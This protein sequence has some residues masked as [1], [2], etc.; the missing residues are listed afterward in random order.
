[1]ISKPRD[2]FISLTRKP[3]GELAVP[4]EGP[5][6]KPRGPSLYVSDVPLPVT[7]EDV[8]Q[9][10]IAEVKFKVD[11]VTK[12][13]TNGETSRSYDFEVLGIRFK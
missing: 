6:L 11:R 9:T 12:S 4:S 1:M 8:G 2:P 7:D 5:E 13:V 3:G 10:L